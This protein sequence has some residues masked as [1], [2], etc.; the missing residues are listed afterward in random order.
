MSSAFG[1]VIETLRFSGFDLNPSISKLL[2]RM[3]YTC[4]AS[5][6]RIDIDEIENTMRTMY[7]DP[8]Y[9]ATLTDCEKN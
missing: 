1:D 3:G 6:S 5:I 4:L 2:I 7:G 8:E 9:F